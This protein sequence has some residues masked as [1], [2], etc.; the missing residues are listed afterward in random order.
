[1]TVAQVRTVLGTLARGLGS[2]QAAATFLGVSTTHVND[3]LLGRRDPGPKLLAALGF[4]RRHVY[5]RSRKE[6]TR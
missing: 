1:M 2:Q 6:D 3:V 5:T 4:Q